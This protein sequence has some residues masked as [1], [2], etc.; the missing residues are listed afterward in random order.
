MVSYERANTVIHR[1]LRELYSP[2]SVSKTTVHLMY[3]IPARDRIENNHDS[4][5]ELL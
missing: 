4:L 3:K 1:K 2:P 5:S